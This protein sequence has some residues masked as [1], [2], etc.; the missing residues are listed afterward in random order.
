QED[1]ARR[2]SLQTDGTLHCEISYRHRLGLGKSRPVVSSGGRGRAS[3][4]PRRSL[5]VSVCVTRGFATRAVDVSAF[6][7]LVLSART[8]TDPMSLPN[9]T[10]KNASRTSRRKRGV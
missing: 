5:G 10:A 2:Q 9:M 3:T 6:R 1:A 4:P 8:V 7:S